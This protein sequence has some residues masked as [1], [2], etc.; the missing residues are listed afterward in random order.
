[1]TQ[2]NTIMLPIVN[3]D[4]KVPKKVLDALTMHEC[5]CTFSGIKSVTEDSV[6][7]YL[8]TKFS[9]SIADQFRPEY[10]LT[11]QAS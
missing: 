7:S 11:S 4:A 9:K 2:E 10:L 3:T 1:M 5:F 8:E 6:R